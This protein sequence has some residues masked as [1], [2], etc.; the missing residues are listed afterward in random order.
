MKKFYVI[1]HPVA[2]SLSPKIHGMFA[3]QFNIDIDYQPLDIE[4]GSFIDSVGTLRREQNPAGANVTVPFKQDAADY[5]TQLTERARVAGA[6]NTL[7]FNG[8]DVYGDNTDGAGFLRDLTG[9]CGIGLVGKRVLVLGA[10][11]AARGVI[12]AIRSQGCARITVA[13]RTIGRAIAL[14]DEMGVH[15]AAY[16]DLADEYEIVVNATSAGLSNA[17]PAVPNTIFKKCEIAYDLV[18]SKY[19]TP[20]MRLA[21][22]SGC[23]RVEDG[24]GMLVEQAAESF[25]VWFGCEPETSSVYKALAL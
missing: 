5:C 21:A 10:G 15:Y 1:G 9:R 23:G 19:G 13:N 2:H 4:P 12:A 24:L 6:V 18:Y 11:G 16:T 3:R 17:A 14:A 8:N 22:E 20:F 25:K 7:T